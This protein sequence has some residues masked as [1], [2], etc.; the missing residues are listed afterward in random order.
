MRNAPLAN[1][2]FRPEE[3]HVAS[4]ENDVV[5]PFGRGNKTMEKPT[6]RR[7]TVQ[8]NLQIERFTGLFAAGMNPTRAMERR[9]YP[10]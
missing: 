2:F 9:R 4:R 3:K 8:A 1:P 6:A 5:P 10:K 7:R